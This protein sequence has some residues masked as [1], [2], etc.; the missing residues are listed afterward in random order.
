MAPWLICRESYV[1]EALALWAGGNDDDPS[2]LL[3]LGGQSM[4]QFGI[5]RD[6]AGWAQDLLYYRWRLAREKGRSVEAELLLGM[7]MRQQA[8]AG[9]ISAA[10]LA[11]LAGEAGHPSAGERCAA[12]REWDVESGEGAR[13]YIPLRAA[14]VETLTSGKVTGWTA[15]Q[16]DPLYLHRA[17]FELRA[18]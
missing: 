1:A 12:L 4:P 13:A 3:F 16:R 7:G 2:R 17:A 11:R 14:V 10:Y 8:Y 15:L 18:V 9:S 6:E 5:G